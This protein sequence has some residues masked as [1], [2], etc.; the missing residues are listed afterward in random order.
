LPA[1][2]AKSSAASPRTDTHVV[3]RKWMRTALA[4]SAASIVSFLVHI[5]PSAANGYYVMLRPLSPGKHVI[6]FGGVLPS[7]SQAVTYTVQVQ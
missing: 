4:L 5:F 1:W 6:N 7:L 2:N 3:R